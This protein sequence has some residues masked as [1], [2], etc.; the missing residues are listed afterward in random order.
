MKF[1]DTFPEFQMHIL[2][3]ALRVRTVVVLDQKLATLK[4]KEEAVLCDA[5]AARRFELSDY[6][7]LSFRCL[8][9]SRQGFGVVRKRTR[10]VVAARVVKLKFAVQL[11]LCDGTVIRW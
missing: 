4:Y 11:G 8:R 3:V 1:V 10:A 5:L 6:P 7:T 2:A 9:G